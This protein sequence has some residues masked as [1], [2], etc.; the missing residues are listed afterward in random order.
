MYV[1]RAAFVDD[2]EMFDASFFG[3][4]GTEAKTMDP[5]QRMLLEV[6]YDA[7]HRAGYD[8]KALMGSDAGVFVGQCNNDFGRIDWGAASDKMNPFTGTGM[9]AS[10]SAN[11]VSYTLGLKGPSMTVDTACS[12][13]GLSEALAIQGPCCGPPGD[14]SKQEL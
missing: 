4:S 11:R 6:S 13:P 8:R 1:R 5:Q 2:V 12:W 14:C 9:S 3:I 7:F 10:I